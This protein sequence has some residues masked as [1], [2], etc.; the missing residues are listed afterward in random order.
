MIS[1]RL[2][3]LYWL[4]IAIE[5]IAPPIQFLALPPPRHSNP[6]PVLQQEYP[7]RNVQWCPVKMDYY[8]Y[9]FHV[10]GCKDNEKVTPH[11]LLQTVD[12]HL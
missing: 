1:R 9:K 11:L 5:S 8:I 12:T 7:F 10:K 6:V 2:S 3:Y 4:K